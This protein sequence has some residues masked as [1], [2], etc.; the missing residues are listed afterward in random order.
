MGSESKQWDSR[1]T[2]AVC[3]SQP[4]NA[5][6]T[7]TLPQG[8]CS[9]RRRLCLP[10]KTP[11][12]PVSRVARR[13]EEREP[14]D[15]ADAGH[16]PVVVLRARRPIV[17][18][19]ER[20]RRRRHPGPNTLLQ[21]ARH[22]ERRGSGGGTTRVGEGE[23]K[24]GRKGGRDHEP[25]YLYGFFWL[26]RLLRHWSMICVVHAFTFAWMNGLSE[27]VACRTCAAKKGRGR[28]GRP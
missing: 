27:S 22:W 11:K 17:L 2:R 14:E 21:H 26:E 8:H 1:P 13:R 9:C 15:R 5:Q 10:R 16:V 18:V 20:G 7:H 6:G 3:H 12:C 19:P 28:R 23:M 24:G 4:T 25:M